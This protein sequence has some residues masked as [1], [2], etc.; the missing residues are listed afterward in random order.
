MSIAISRFHFPGREGL[1][2]A[3]SREADHDAPS[4]ERNREDQADRR[5]PSS[6]GAATKRA[7]RR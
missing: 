3:V 1:R 2:A 5:I 6:L 7:R 4:M